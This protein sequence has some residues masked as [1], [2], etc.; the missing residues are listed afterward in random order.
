MFLNVRNAFKNNPC[1]MRIVKK[2]KEKYFEMKDYEAVT[3]KNLQAITK[4]KANQEM[5]THSSTLVWKI[6]WMEETG[7]LQSMGSLGV[8]H[9]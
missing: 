8:G 6:P 7:G 1:I 4:T 3:Y 2:N 9:Y 5:A